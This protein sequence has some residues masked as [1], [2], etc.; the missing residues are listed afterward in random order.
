MKIKFLGATKTVTGSKT[1]LE[2]KDKR[3]LIDCGM[4]QGP[5]VLT[6]LNKPE[7]DFDASRLDS[8]FLT[9]AHYDH[10]GYLPVLVKN[11]FKGKIVSTHATMQ[12]VKIILEDSVKVQESDLEK[13]KIKELLYEQADVEKTLSYFVNKEVGRDYFD[14]GF[15][16]KFYEAGHILGATS[17]VFSFGGEGVCFS[18]DL[19][20]KD[21]LIHK[22]AD[23]PVNIDYL[24]LESTY[25][26]RSHTLDNPLD[27][28]K[29][30]IID[31]T[32]SNGVL[33]I[34]SF[35]VARTQ[36]LI[37]YL[38][39]LFEAEPDIKLPVFVD[40]PMGI[41]ATRIY[42]E[43]HM[44]LKVDKEKF[45]SA[46]KMVKFVEF[47]D[48]HKKLARKK[49]PFIIISSSGMISGGKVLKYFD[50]YAKH[51]KNT[52]LLAGYQSEGTIGHKILNGEKVIPLFGH[53]IKIRARVE[54]ISSLSAHA[55]AKEMKQLILD[56]SPKLKKIYLNHGEEQSKLIFK[57]YLQKDTIWKVEIANKNKWYNLKDTK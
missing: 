18:G 50:M 21:D 24:V 32:K 31:I 5:S 15:G 16:Y 35:A 46:C 53:D 55:D 52:I 57:K 56:H 9:H 2:I 33:L 39:D 7:P 45:K 20:R 30:N 11:G 28:L 25:G 27:Q 42:L 6:E 43:N 3:I 22:R 34:P 17:I 8:I 14:Q 12:L 10:S 38:F 19:G 44:L 36:I 47:G 51:E 29:Q 41:R 40:S 54:L 37:Q 4:Y 48:D 13:K 23:F 26:D 1:F 49:A